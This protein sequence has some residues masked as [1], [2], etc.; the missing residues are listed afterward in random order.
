MCVV[1]PKDLISGLSHLC[2]KLVMRFDMMI[3]IVNFALQ[4]LLGVSVETHDLV[5]IYLCN[6]Y[7]VLFYES[8]FSYRMERGKHTCHKG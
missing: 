2:R 5:R 3:H 6:Q 4:K 1:L 8:P 7:P